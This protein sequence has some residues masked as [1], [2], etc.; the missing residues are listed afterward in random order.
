MAG[1][2]HTKSPR[3]VRYTIARDAKKVE[4]KLAKAQLDREVERELAALKHK[5][6][7]EKSQ[8]EFQALAEKQRLTRL[9][10]K[11]KKR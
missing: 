11:A 4:Q 6:F 2:H 8:N 1:T 3:R 5:L 7:L 9:S 10:G